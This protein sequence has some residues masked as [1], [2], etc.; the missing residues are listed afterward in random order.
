M[1]R[2]QIIN[3]IQAKEAEFK[4]ISQKL[5]YNPFDAILTIR[6]IALDHVENNKWSNN[7]E[8]RDHSK[9]WDEL[10]QIEKE[11][12]DD[13]K[14]CEPMVDLVAKG[15]ELKLEIN[16]LKQQLTWAHQ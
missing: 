16:S 15:Y 3:E 12:V 2:E 13:L 4:E 8:L 7:K 9:Q 14:Q 6:A 1:N 11:M 5:V 10:R